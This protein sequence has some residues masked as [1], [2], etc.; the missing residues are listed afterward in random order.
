[1]DNPTN[2]IVILIL[3]GLL[4]R[5]QEIHAEGQQLRILMAIK[6]NQIDCKFLDIGTKPTNGFSN[7][8]CAKSVIDELVSP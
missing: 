4:L 2:L 7:L 3:L 1:M 5:E 6:V 8:F